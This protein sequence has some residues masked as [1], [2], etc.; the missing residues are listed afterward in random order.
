MSA[1]H[2]QAWLESV[3]GLSRAGWW[4]PIVCTHGSGSL[5]EADVI[6]VLFDH[7]DRNDELHWAPRVMRVSGEGTLTRLLIHQTRLDESERT[8]A[9]ARGL[10]G[11]VR[12]GSG[13]INTE[14]TQGHTA[15]FSRE[16]WDTAITSARRA[17]NLPALDVFGR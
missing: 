7:E 10:Q 17:G 3:G 12:F 15:R 13:S 9:R 16:Q 6:G 11:Q 5:V 4:L 8:Q 1:D 2:W 14:C